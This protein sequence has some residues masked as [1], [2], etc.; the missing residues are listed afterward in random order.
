[1][2]SELRIRD[3]GVIND[4]VVAPHP[5]L[6]VVTGETG[7]GK[8]MI[9]TGIGLLLGDRAEARSVRS[10]TERAVVEG[11][12]TVPGGTRRRAGWPA[13][14]ATPAA[15]WTTTSWWWPGTSPRPA[16]RARSWAGPR[17]RCRSAPR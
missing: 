1:M 4:A 6:T 11:R 15:T 9:V 2:I 13:G 14:S 5:G 16:G 7:A 17:C 12:L 8:T 3:L 10:G